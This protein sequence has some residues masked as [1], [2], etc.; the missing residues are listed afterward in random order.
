MDTLLHQFNRIFELKYQGVIYG[1]IARIVKEEYGDNAYAQSTIQIE[2]AP[3]GSWYPLY[4]QYVQDEGERKV[5]EARS[6]FRKEAEHATKVI[7][8][9]LNSAANLHDYDKAVR[10]A[11][12]ILSFG[13]VSEK[14]GAKTPL[15][16]LSDTEFRKLL[17][18]NGVDAEAIFNI[19]SSQEKESN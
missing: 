14:V 11:Q 16:N 6:I 10:Y 4:R 2:L 8:E 12:I 15:R 5:E 18:E 13:D 19:R 9:A 17:T 7:V 1:E 3:T